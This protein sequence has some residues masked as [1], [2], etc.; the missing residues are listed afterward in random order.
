[1]EDFLARW[2][3][4][5]VLLGTFFEGETVLVL[6]G[7]AAHQGLLQLEW[8]IACAFAGSLSGDMLW[9]T[10][11]RR[12]GRAWLERHPGKA[13]VVERAARLLERWGDWFVLSFRFLYGLRSVSP[14]AVGLTAMPA[15]R[16]AALNVVAALVWAAA[17][18]SLG[19][20]FGNTVEAALGKLQ[21]WEHRIMVALGIAVALYVLHRVL[22]RRNGAV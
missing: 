20:V 3:Y 4:L 5:A 6:A 9:F 15:V 21:A 10:M 7:F 14:V 17:V 8:V 11:G 16:F 22:R 1:M 2:G 19:Y 13:V 18:G 12:F